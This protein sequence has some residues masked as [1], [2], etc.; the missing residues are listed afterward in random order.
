MDEKKY[1]VDMKQTYKT[2]MDMMIDLPLLADKF[3]DVYEPL[4]ALAFKK[5]EPEEHH[6]ELV[7][8]T[9][10]A[11]HHIEYYIDVPA[12]QEANK[13]YDIYKEDLNDLGISD[14]DGLLDSIIEFLYDV[15]RFTK[16]VHQVEVEEAT[17]EDY[18]RLNGQFQQLE[19]SPYFPTLQ[20]DIDTLLSVHDNYERNN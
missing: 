14:S 9:D 8:L 2:L 16:A 19:L 1:M 7:R 10:H 4:S 17:T 12:Y 18:Q 3:N 13:F 15:E 20:M 6:E 5:G 11:M